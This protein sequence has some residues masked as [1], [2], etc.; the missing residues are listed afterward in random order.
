MAALAAEA[1]DIAAR[2]QGSGLPALFLRRAHADPRPAGQGRALRPEPHPHPGDI[3]RALLEGIACGTNHVIETYLE[4]A[5]TR[6][7]SSP[8]AAAPRTA[9]GR[10][11]PR[12]SRAA[13]SRAREDRRRVLRR[14]VPRRARGRRRRSRRRSARGTRSRRSSRRSRRTPRCIGGGIGFSASS[15]RGR[16]ILCESSTMRLADCCRARRRPL[17]LG[18]GGLRVFASLRA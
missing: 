1:A 5:Q 14:R 3:F 13:P 18:G 12:T 11:Q 6:A 4:A 7:R 16:R 17:A 10:R 9:S 15:I 8:S 2:R